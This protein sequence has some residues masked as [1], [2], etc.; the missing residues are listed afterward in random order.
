M[1]YIHVPARPVE[2]KFSYRLFA[3]TVV[4]TLAA[5]VGALR[6]LAPGPVWRTQ[7]EAPAWKWVAALLAITLFNCFV[8]YFFHRYV[9]HKP[10][11]PLLNRFYRQHTKHHNLTR[12]VRKRTPGGTEVPF[13]ENLY[14]ILEPEQGEAS[15]FPWYTL[16]VFACLLTPLFMLLQWIL[17]SFPWF[18]S[19]FVAL[20]ASLTLYELFHAIE[21]WSLDRWG[22]LLDS[23]R[24][25]GFWRT[26]Y[27]FHLRHH[28]VIDCNEAISGFFTLPVADLV[29][30][31]CLIPKTL[32]ADGEEWSPANFISPKPCRLIA[33]AD[34]FSDAMVRTRRERAAGTA[35]AAE[36]GEATRG[37]RI[38]RGLTQGLGLCVSATALA[39]L[40]IFSIL[41]GDAWHVVSFTIFGVT[42]LALYLSSALYHGSRAAHWRGLFRKFDHAAAFLLVAGSY[43]PFLLVSLRGPWGWTLFGIVWGLCIAGVVF[44]LFFA[45]RFRLLTTIACLSLGWLVLIALKPLLASVPHGGIWLLLAGGL[46]YTVGAVF[47]NWVRLR[48]ADAMW[49]TL[50]LGGSVCHFLAVL[51]FLLPRAA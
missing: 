30:G 5:F 16:A 18:I 43:T 23:P 13:V 15:F 12:I 38:A 6:L 9:L 27:G 10:I 46:C 4:G 48:Y 21:H 34:R 28:A 40:V 39:L 24:W 17:P 22:P 11:V 8:E 37:E 49:Q 51:L 41:R 26:V 25:G 2:E 7:F 1:A 14:P 20:T 36:A 47:C 33:W 19:G 3:V 45:G 44:Q 42:L 50:V 31:T 35:P 29:F 32:Y